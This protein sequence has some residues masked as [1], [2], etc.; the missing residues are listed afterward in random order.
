MLLPSKASYLPGESVHVDVSPAGHHRRLRVSHLGVEVATTD[1][2]PG[3]DRVVLPALPEGGYAV[4]LLDD[5]HDTRWTAV[6]IL[7]DPVSR[8]RYGFVASFAPGRD[9]DA[10][11]SHFRRLHLSGAQF[12]DWA[13]RHAD[14]VGP[15]EYQDPLGQPVA[16]ETVQ[17]L[18]GGLRDGGTLPIGY[19]AVY[20]VGKD[21]WPAWEHI[22]L[23]QPDG[24]P[25]ALGDFLQLVDPS[26][27]AWLAHF[28]ADLRAAV[29]AGS[30]AGFHL[31]QYGWPRHAMRPDGRSV[32][33]ARAFDTLIQAVRTALPE[34]TLIFNNVNDFPAWVT[35]ASPQDVTYTEVWDPHHTLADLAA[36]ATRSRTLAPT[37]PAVLA[38]YQTVY[39]NHPPEVADL[40]TRFT[41]ATAF[42]HGATQ[43]LA[44]ES[45]SVLVDPYYVRNHRV[46]PSTSDLLQRWY[47]LLVAAGDVLLAPGIHDITRSVAGA[48][49]DEIDVIGPDGVTISH[50]ARPGTVWRRVVDTPQG[51]VMHLINLTGQEETGWD[52]PKA[53]PPPVTGL[54]LRMRR[55]VPQLPAIRVADPDRGPAFAAVPAVAD[56]EH[57]EAELP[58]LDVWE[59]VFIPR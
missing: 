25:Y 28:T 20:G 59:I 14:L 34:A 2:A 15:V 7:A 32:D 55:C 51:I 57:V 39:A 13:Y 11:L 40:T 35:T 50:E 53:A 54:R 38:A 45:G 26:D 6:E 49:N 12:Y 5:R 10:V 17:R 9:V 19:A 4:A 42:S 22:A 56:G 1:V 30:F 43:L 47:D 29:R 24:T 21:E 31:D 41:M 27:P 16:I 58:P 36:V 37:R 48:Y 33:L 23:V 3:A 46:L 8:L 18:A 52:T 44:G